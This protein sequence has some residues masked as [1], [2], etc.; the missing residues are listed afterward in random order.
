MLSLEELMTNDPLPPR[1]KRR[2]LVVVNTGDGKGKTTSSLGVAFRALGWNWK[3]RIIQFIKGK[4][5]TGEKRFC[6]ALPMHIEL[7]PMGDG[8]TWDTK[9]PEQD[10][11]TSAEIWAFARE[12]IEK[13]EH[14]LVI[15]D[16][17]N[18]VID[19]DYL[20]VEPVIQTLKAREPWMH[21]ICTGRNARE[22]L[23][24]Y[25][26]LVTEMKEIKHPFNQGVVAQRGVDF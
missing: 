17:I 26:D 10:K 25:A 11:K 8:F 12:S 3:I 9:N 6:D 14:D 18:N 21:V 13:A 1:E 4:W 20:E 15:L 19:Y 5:L 23:I 7:F 16:E 22:E 2:G 24:E